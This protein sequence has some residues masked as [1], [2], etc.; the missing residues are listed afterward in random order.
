[1]HTNLQGDEDN[2][3]FINPFSI[4]NRKD[5]DENTEGEVTAEGF[6]KSP[7]ITQTQDER[8]GSMGIGNS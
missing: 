7:D 4:A 5:S 1:M 6:F 3:S 2:Q 8:T